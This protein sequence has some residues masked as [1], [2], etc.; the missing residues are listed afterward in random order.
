MTS[1]IKDGGCAYPCEYH[2]RSGMHS[3]EKVVAKGMSLRDYFASNARND[4]IAFPDFDTAARW[5]GVPAPDE[6]SY[7][8]MLEFSFKLK[9][10][11]GYMQADAMIAA[12]EASQ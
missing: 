2:R 3:T 4:D 7:I 12:R 9:A 5:V 6:N 1:T 10:K 11:I 8:A